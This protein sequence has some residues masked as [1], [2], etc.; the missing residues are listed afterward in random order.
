MPSWEGLRL[1]ER[2]SRR[3]G[4][5]AA[6]ENDADA[7]ALG[8]SAWGAGKGAGRFIYVTFSTGIGA[9]IVLDGQL[10]RGVDGA[11]PEIGHHIIDPSG[12]ACACGARGCWESLASG[13]AL[14]QRSGYASA[15]EACAAAERGEARA[16]A[17]VREEGRYLGIGLANLVTIFTPDRIALGG[18]LMRSR[19]LFWET[20]QDSIRQYCGM[21][22]HEKTSILPA[23]LGEDSG[24]AGAARAWM[25]RYAGE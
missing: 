14:A 15:R 21:V 19:D 9:G 11:H 22:P 13:L 1:T 3:F 17:A 24:L 4:V 7:A 8:E 12:P 5:T 23:L 18:G 25:H 10:Y 16:C 2:L 6:M 20:I